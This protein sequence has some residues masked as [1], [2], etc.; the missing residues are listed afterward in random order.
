MKLV[1]FSDLHAHEYQAHAKVGPSGLNTRLEHSFAV[2][3]EIVRFSEEI[4]AWTLFLGDL[5][6]IKGM[7]S[8]QA[9]NGLMNRFLT[10][11][12]FAAAM[13]PGN[14]DMASADGEQHALEPFKTLENIEVWDSPNLIAPFE[15]EKL[16]VG[17]IP[18]PMKNGKFDRDRFMKSLAGLSEEADRF[19]S[20]SYLKILIAHVYTHELMRKYVGIDGDVSAAELVESFDMA[21]LGHHHIH[22]VI[23]LG[24]GKRVVSVG[25]PLQLTFNDRGLEKGCVVLDTETRRIEFHVLDAPRFRAFEGEKS[26]VPEE[27]KGDF[28]RV[29]VASKAEA[30]RVKK[31]LEEAGA[32]SVVVEL[33]PAA[34]KS[35]IDLEPGAK[36]AD[37]LKKYISSEWGETSLDKGRLLSEGARF[38]PH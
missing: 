18:Y 33:V 12:Y 17:A 21:F 16:I 22:E 35:R 9:L 19:P 23:T 7:V 4:R 20:D 2:V 26:I 1:F 3:D 13:I 34:T 29:R 10:A 31:T 6:H 28:V 5:F 27:V 24:E 8:V 37:I 38:L 11:G 15:D 36:D 25:S 30:T 14:H 32:A